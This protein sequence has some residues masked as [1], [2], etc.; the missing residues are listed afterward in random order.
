MDRKQE[1]DSTTGSNQRELTEDP[2]L[3]K[4][5]RMLEDEV[6]RTIGRASDGEL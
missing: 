1:D 4:A 3:L 2:Y 5:I 6:E